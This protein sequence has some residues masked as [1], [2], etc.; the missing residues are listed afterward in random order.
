MG[1]QIQ[2]GV[3][4]GVLALLGTGIVCLGLNTAFGGIATLGWQG[5]TE[6]FTI[7]KPGEFAVQDNHVRF[8]GGVFL[9]TGFVFMAS[10]V[11][12][13]SLK[14]TLNILIGLIFIG[15]LV[16]FSSMDSSLLT[17]SAIL[18]SLV[19]ELIV[20]PLLGL[21]IVSVTAKQQEPAPGNVITGG[22]L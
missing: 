1:L 16:R 10:A 11:F 14:E 4:R 21:W 15:G 9:G 17:S 3:L 8:L 12:I 6:F 5:G 19:F 18:P 2:I 7:A 13:N 22:E 20:F